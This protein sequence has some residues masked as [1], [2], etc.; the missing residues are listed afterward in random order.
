MQKLILSAAVT[1]AL[2]V[3]AIAQDQAGATATFMNAE[4]AEVGSVTLTQGE[5]SVSITGELT[6]MTPG[7]HGFHF[8]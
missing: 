2:I 7:E 6:G 8:H 3:P 4:G 1:L 5:G